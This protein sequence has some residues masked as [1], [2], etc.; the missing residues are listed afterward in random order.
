VG[1]DIG[2]SLRLPAS[3]TGIVTLKPSN[4]TVPIDPPYHG[5]VAGPM[6][7][8]VADAALLMR[9]L[10]QPD[11]RDHRSLP[12]RAVD[13]TAL[14]GAEEAV[15]GLRIGLLTEAGCGLPTDPEVRAAVQAAAEV[16]ASAGAV[17]EP[18]EP[19]FG[20]EML[21]DLDLFWRVRG[22]LD[23][24]SMPPERQAAVL[25][26]IAAWC[27]G[28]AEVPGSVLMRC[29]NRMLEISRNTVAATQP[30]DYVLSPVSP[31]PAFPAEWPSPTNDVDRPMEHITF[32]VPYNMSEQ[33]ASSINCGWTREG[34]P[35]GLQIAGRRF[36]DLGVLRM[37]SWFELARPR[38]AAPA[39][40]RIRER[41][42]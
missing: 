17:V 9:V 33:P 31:V 16:F 20:R 39:W 27:R 41:L 7:R 22:W 42:T 18:V 37:T 36:D 13:W 1:T 28:G 10:A 24:S 8:T 26:Y 6:T 32:T 21:D 5:R 19:F 12:V 40:D 11:W 4:G 23:L 29:V 30:F 34:S 15:R 3:W 2:G 14:D 25:P 35:I 38:E